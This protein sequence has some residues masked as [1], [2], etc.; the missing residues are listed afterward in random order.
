M[1]QLL[2]RKHFGRLQKTQAIYTSTQVSQDHRCCEQ[3]LVTFVTQLQQDI[4]LVAEVVAN[5]VSKETFL[6][7]VWMQVLNVEGASVAKHAGIQL[8]R[9]K[10]FVLLNSTSQFCSCQRGEEEQRDTPDPAARQFIA[11]LHS[12]L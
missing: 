8:M 4:A 12:A 11:K 3:L 5:S 10:H 6:G 2:T 1:I 9:P 7:I